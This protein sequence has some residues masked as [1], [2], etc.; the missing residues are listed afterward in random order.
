MVCNSLNPSTRIRTATH[1]SECSLK[2]DEHGAGMQGR[3][4]NRGGEKKKKG[5]IKFLKFG[6]ESKVRADF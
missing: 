3:I 5:L 6:K 4:A 1:W 2:D